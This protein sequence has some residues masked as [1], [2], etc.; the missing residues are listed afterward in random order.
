MTNTS[1]T[2][3]QVAG[4]LKD[5]RNWGRWPDNPE[6]G[7]VNLITAEKR[8]QAAGLVKTG[9]AVSLARPLPL[10]PAPNNPTPVHYYL[11]KVDFPEGGGGVTDFIGVSYHGPSTTHI[12][13]LCHT[14]GEEGMWEGRDPA[15]EI[16]T[17]GASWGSIEAWSGGIVTRGVLL[18]VP[19]HRGTSY[20]ALDSPVHGDELEEIVTAQ[21]VEL[22]PG[23]AVAVYC[24]REAFE[25]D[26]GSPWSSGEERPGL[27]PS[28]LPFLRDHDVSAL[29]W[30]MTDVGPREHGAA[31]TVHGAIFAYGVAL[32][33]SAQLGPLAAAC[34]EEGRYDF[35]LTISPLII[36]GGTGSPVNPIAIF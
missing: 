9:R 2:R 17:E 10:D 8:V 25:E 13:A 24:G 15:V 20:V 27:D 34:A 18:D 5:G 12:D 16:T 23:D 7:A 35:M 33:D 19:A 1:P 29:L 4:Y 32:V 30:D 26:A 28:C 22:E 31:L 11:K 6:A 36:R 3:E 21:G 14:W